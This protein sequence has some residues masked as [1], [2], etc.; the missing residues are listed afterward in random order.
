MKYLVMTLLLM[1]LLGCASTS[2]PVWQQELNN[3]NRQWRTPTVAS[4]SLSPS[5]KPINFRPLRC[6]F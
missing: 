2:A 1:G 4:V 3:F 5:H 6:M